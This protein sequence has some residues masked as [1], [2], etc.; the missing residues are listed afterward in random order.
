MRDKMKVLQHFFARQQPRQS[1][2]LI[3]KSGFGGLTGIALLGLLSQSTDSLWLMAPFGAT[4]VLLFSVPASPLSQPAN[5]IAGHLLST[6]IGLA[7][8]TFLPMSWWAIGLAVGLA[9]AAMAVLR[10]SH[11][12]AGADP[13]VVFLESPGWDYLGFPVLSGSIILVLVAWLVH[14]AP[15]VVHYPIHVVQQTK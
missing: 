15:P 1:N 13:L 3:I 2:S 4:C 7:L 8:H 12:P 6:S 9:I 11:P 14:R 10:I 5:V